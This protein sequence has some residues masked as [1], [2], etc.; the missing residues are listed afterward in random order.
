VRRLIINADDFGLTA[1]VNRAIL[2]AHQCGVVTSTTLMAG[3][4]EFE[5]AVRLAQS[6]PRLGLGCHVVLVDGAPVLKAFQIPSLAKCA[7][8]GRAGFR[9]SWS[10]IAAAALAGRL[11]PEEIEAETAAQIR[12]LQSAGLAVS[13]L[14]THKHTHIFPQILRPMLRAAK[15]C[16]I[17]A[18]RNPFGPVHLAQLAQQ[19]ALWNRWIG[20]RTLNRFARS[21]RKMVA[22][23]GLL[24]PEGTLGIVATGMLDEPALAT[25]FENLPQGTWELVCH[26]GYPD[27]QLSRV[28][29][30]LRESRLRELSLLTSTRTRA[31][32]A[33]HAV[34]LISY[35]DL[36]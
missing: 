12:R 34:Q 13:H 8:E 5:D 29:T 25:I 20:T 10:R 4:E 1:G 21:F 26:P 3:G 23:E 32:L 30:R 31:L 35:A 16:G 7:R 22:G 19:P 9:Q 17:R 6:V 2:E 24:T 33:H 14:D 28:R 18:L 27:E 36:G 11:V 15:E